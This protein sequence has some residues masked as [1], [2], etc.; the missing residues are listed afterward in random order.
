MV[1][2]LYLLPVCFVSACAEQ[3]PFYYDNPA[4]VSIPFLAQSALV[5][6]QDRTRLSAMRATLKIAGGKDCP[7][8]VNPADLS[9]SGRCE[10]ISPGKIRLLLLIYALKHPT[11]T[12]VYSLAYAVSYVDLRAGPINENTTEVEVNF[13]TEN[14]YYQQE[15][16]EAQL[17]EGK[18]LALDDPQE[19]ANK[20]AREVIFSELGD[21]LDK[22][23][24]N[25]SNMT[26]A[27]EGTLF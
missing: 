26:E 20:W 17:P 25:I 2:S 19:A 10:N 14:M 21:N 11:A 18:I 8:Q 23:D 24:D 5:N 22:D 27:C 12:V 1:K 16:V 9:V 3:N 7:L 6:C 15:D 13:S 4:A